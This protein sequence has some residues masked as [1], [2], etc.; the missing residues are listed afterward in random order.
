MA[1]GVSTSSEEELRKLR[2][3][4]DKLIY[5]YGQLK[6]AIDG[7]TSDIEAAL[8]LSALRARIVA[9]FV[10]GKAFTNEQLITAAWQSEADSSTVQSV[11]CQMKKSLPWFKVSNLKSG[12]RRG[13]LYQMDKSSIEYVK[14]K[15]E[16]FQV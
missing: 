8:N 15:V 10:T 7:A 2:A 5:A 13:A 1:Y 16:A 11:L 14:R 3:E 9:V 4:Y 6:W 12:K